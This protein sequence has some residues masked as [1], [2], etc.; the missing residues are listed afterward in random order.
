M[1]T[2]V[3]RAARAKRMRLI[4]G[5]LIAAPIIG[6]LVFIAVDSGW[7]VALASLL[8]VAVICACAFFGAG[9]LECADDC[10]RNSGG[11]S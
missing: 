1:N 6:V 2:G 11:K 3:T 4:G 9:L 5:M 10:E 8:V 7:K